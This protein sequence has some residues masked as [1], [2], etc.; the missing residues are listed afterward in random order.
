MRTIQSEALP[1]TMAVIDQGTPQAISQGWCHLQHYKYILSKTQTC[2]SDVLLN[3][4]VF[5][6]LSDLYIYI[7]PYC[8]NVY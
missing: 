8:N 4:E 2:F 1:G 7:S 6:F 3:T 5:Y